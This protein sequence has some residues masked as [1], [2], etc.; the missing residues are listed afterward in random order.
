MQPQQALN[1]EQPPNEPPVL[2]DAVETKMDATITD[3]QSNSLQK[4]FKDPSTITR[5]TWDKDNMY[6]IICIRMVTIQFIH[7]NHHYH[8]VQ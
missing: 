1:E 4:H 5:T 2:K 6:C 7:E 8:M 3:S